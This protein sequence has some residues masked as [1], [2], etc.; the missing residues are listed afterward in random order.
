MRDFLKEK[1]VPVLVVSC[2]ILFVFLFLMMTD[3]ISNVS[4]VEADGVG[5][6]WDSSCSD[7]VS[8]IDWGALAPA[9]AENIVVY[10]RNEIEDPACFVLSTD[11]WNPPEASQCLSLSWNYSGHRVSPQET[12]QTMLT[13]SVS[14]SIEGIST[15]SLHITI[16][17]RVSLPF[18]I[19]SDG[20]IDIYDVTEVALALGSQ[21]E[22]DPQT[23]QDE[24]ENWNPHADIAL[25]YGI[26]D[27]YDIIAVTPHFGET[28]P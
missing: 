19:N 25:Q 15:F 13:L 8:S 1:V 27:I 18:D 24:S 7:K 14:P 28:Y 5:I 16:T 4:A 21:L 20:S 9:S 11:N 22:D 3:T 17:A 12:L 23:P 6:Y 2:L 10:I 26:I